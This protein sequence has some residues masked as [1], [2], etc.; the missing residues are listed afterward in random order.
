MCRQAV[1]RLRRTSASLKADRPADLCIAILQA[2]T[3][4]WLLTIKL[5]GKK[6]A[7]ISIAV[8][9]AFRETTTSMTSTN[10]QDVELLRQTFSEVP[11]AQQAKGWEA[12]WQKKVTPWDRSRPNL[13]LVDTLNDKSSIL[14]SPMRNGTRR[15]ALVPGC[16]AGY[17]V[18]LLSSYGYDAV[19]LDTAETAITN[20]RQLQA[21]EEKDRKDYP[22][23][24]QTIGPGKAE[25]LEENFFEDAFLTKVC[26]TKF[27]LIY[28]YTFLCALPP[29]MRPQWAKRMSDLLAPEGTLICVEFPL[30]KP[31]SAGGPPHGLN[32]TVYEALFRS[33]GREITHNNAGEAENSGTAQGH[34][35]R[36]IA[37]WA[38]ARSHHAGQGKDMVSLWQH[39]E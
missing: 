6:T 31:L 3:H 33:P 36:R 5:D 11:A 10:T 18:V 30:G 19:G 39:G 29:E 14:G 13:A 7:V 20:A 9:H 17:D 34:R 22:V 15:R 26:T 35:L 23:H 4:Y 2:W 1:D 37:H 24:D 28:D 16:G 25:F 8:P 12:L 32:S 38:P 21:A 27:D